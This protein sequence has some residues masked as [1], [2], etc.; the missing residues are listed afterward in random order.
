MFMQLADILGPILCISAIGYILGRSSVGI[1]TRTLSTVVILIATP[2]LIFHTLTSLHV[3]GDTIET[4]AGAAVLCVAIAGALGL[5]T[6]LLLRGPVR[7]F[8]PPLM[9]PNSGNMGLPLVVLTFGPEG[10][11]F[12]VAYFFVVA[13]LQNSLGLSIYAGSLRLKVIF[14]QPLIY[15]VLAVLVVT[16][17]D[18]QVPNIILTTTEMLG[19]MMVPAMLLLLGASL[20]TLKVEDLRP[21]LLVAVGRLVFGVISALVVIWLLGLSGMVAGTVFLMATM[22]TAILMF[23]FA[24]RY[25]H[26]AKQVAGSVVVSTLLTF[27]CLPL[28]VWAALEI[29]GLNSDFE[30]SLPSP[31]VTPYS[32]SLAQSPS[33][34]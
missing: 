16:W 24:E 25:Q 1:E 10:M 30:A 29:S 14:R 34:E 2:S 5:L 7:S 33:K 11:P 3:T 8:L 6:L 26:D 4:M 12:G 32:A 22:P 27:A 15:A 31:L 23:V 19:G 20:A 9:M 13:L 17:A 28:I 21:A 18:I